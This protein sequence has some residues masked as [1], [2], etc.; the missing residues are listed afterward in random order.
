M[1]EIA[2]TTTK[3]LQQNSNHPDDRARGRR[4]PLPV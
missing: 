3:F 1:Q 4:G 2:K